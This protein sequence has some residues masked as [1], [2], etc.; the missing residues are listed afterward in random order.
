MTRL[1]GCAVLAV[2]SLAAAEDDPILRA[3]RD[4]VGR[5]RSIKVEK[6]ESPYYVEAAVEDLEQFSAVATLGG[7]IRTTK[8]RVRGPRLR[9]R[10][11]DYA[12]DNSNYVGSDYPFSGSSDTQLPL[13]GV[14]PVLRRYLW[15]AIDRSYK[16]AVEAIARKRAAL[17]NVSMTGAIADFTKAEPVRRIEEIRPAPFD[18]PG[19]TARAQ[20]VSAVFAQYPAVRNSGVELE[21]IRNVHYMVTSEGTEI[22]M[23]ERVA[24]LRARAS[25]QAPDGMLLRD[26]LVLHSLEFDRLASEA[27]M[28]R[29]VKALAENLTALAAAPIGETYSGPVMFE[30]E[31]AG[32]LF[33]QLLGKNLSLLRRPA[34]EPGQSF[35]FPSNELEGKIGSR[36]LPD[37]MDVADDPT[38]KEFRGQPLIGAYTVDMEGVEAK[39][40]SLVEKGV[41]KSF[42][43][44]RQPHRGLSGSNGRARLPGPFGSSQATMSNLFVRAR[45]TVGAGELKKKLIEMTKARGK[46]YGLLIRKLDFPS[47]AAMD[48]LRRLYGGGGQSAQ[49]PLS[50]PI[51]AYRVYPDG[52]EELVRGLR[53]RGLSVR[54]LKD[55]LLASEETFVFQFLDNPAPLAVM[56]AG[57]YIAESCV[58]APSI[59]MD[60]VELERIEQEFP[61]VPIVPPPG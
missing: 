48:E 22:R 11:G 35:P 24:F 45:E 46:D 3:L 57:G 55:I 13:E 37:W 59:L 9:V 2:L 54:S 38:Q 7:L 61:K 52:R 49:R 51:L 44:T 60:D 16:N 10:V 33:A 29:A 32:Q 21:A 27:E 53:F 40:L 36:I 15:L 18:E 41:M 6:L 14:Y 56:G 47:S 26:A 58:V 50:I 8:N 12:F 17:K 28:T 39:P 25:S 19:W 34:M 5:S 4:E 20:A 31:A 42:L 30:R 43:M 23:A 1:C